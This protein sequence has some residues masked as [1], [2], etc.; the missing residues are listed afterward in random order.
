MIE[1][2]DDL[3]EKIREAIK[4]DEAVGEPICC[5]ADA[6]SDLIEWIDDNV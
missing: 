4:N 3:I 5:T 6:V 1:V 2:P